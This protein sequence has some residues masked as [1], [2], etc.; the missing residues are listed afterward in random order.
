MAFLYYVRPL[1]HPGNGKREEWDFALNAALAEVTM[2]LVP[3]LPERKHPTTEIG[4]PDLTKRPHSQANNRRL[5][6][7]LVSVGLGH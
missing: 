3:L 2:V 5:V 4:E 6:T 1:N 7:P